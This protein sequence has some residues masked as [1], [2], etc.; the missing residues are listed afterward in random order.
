MTEMT[1]VIDRGK[2]I[3]KTSPVSGRVAILPDSVFA[4]FFSSFKQGWGD[5]QCDAQKMNEGFCPF[6]VTGY[7]EA[8]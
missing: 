3:E 4:S 5:E 6:L 1:L 2:L 7:L 8:W